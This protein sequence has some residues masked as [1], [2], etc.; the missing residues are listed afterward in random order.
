[1]GNRIY[2]CDD[3]QS[4]CPWNK[5]ARTSRLPDFDERAG[6]NG[7]SL[8]HLLSWSE[9]EFLQRTEGSAIRRIGH[10]RWLRNAAVAAGNALRMGDAGAS[11]LRDA[12]LARLG[13]DS[14]I[15]REHAQWALAQIPMQADG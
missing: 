14:E 12:L 1:M 7:Q 6:L 4:V 15:V 11:A 5:Y 13:H 10:V 9:A 8:A 3:C 2:G